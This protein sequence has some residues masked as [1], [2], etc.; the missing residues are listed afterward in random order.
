MPAASGVAVRQHQP[1]ETARRARSTRGR[2]RRRPVADHRHLQRAGHERPRPRRGPTR[3]TAGRGRRPPRR[4]ERRLGRVAV[5]ASPVRAAYVSSAP[6][7]DD[8]PDG[9][10]LSPWRTRPGEERLGVVG[11]V[12]EAAVVGAEVRRRGVE[13]LAGGL[14]PAGAHRW[15]GAGRAAP[16]RGCRSRRAHRPR[17]RR[18]CRGRPAAAVRRR[19]WVEHDARRRPRRPHQSGSAEQRACVGEPGDRQAVPRRHDL[20][21]PG[22]LRA[23]LAGVEQP[24]AHAVP[25]RRVVGVGAQLERR[26]PVLERPVAR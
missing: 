7:S 23:L 1:G 20:V 3:R 10:A 2:R 25:P 6:A 11:R 4:S 24:L 22:R 21:V 5:A 9:S 18:P 8:S 15:P 26:R 19:R 13:Q 16:R 12:V 17:P 14:E